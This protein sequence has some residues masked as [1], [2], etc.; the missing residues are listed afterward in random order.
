[1]AASTCPDGEKIYMKKVLLLSSVL[2]LMFAC[3]GNRTSEGPEFSGHPALTFSRQEAETV[4]EMLGVNPYV[5]KAVND[6]KSRIE[7]SMKDGIDVPQP[8][9]A[10][11]YAHEK[12]KQNY[13]DMKMAGLLYVI[14]GNVKYAEF[15]KQMLNQY[16]ELYPTLGA[17]P[18]SHGQRPGKLFHQMLNETV[19]LL[20]TSQ[21]YDYIYDYLTPDERKRYE[22]N[23]FN[24]MADWFTKDHPEEFNRIHNHGMWAAASV[25]MYGLVSGQDDYVQMALYGT[26]KDGNG[27]FMAQVDKLFSPDGYYMEGAYYV[28][29]ALRPL[30]FF[31]EALERKRPDLKIYEFKDHII[32]KA[33]YAAIQM[34]YPN[35]VFIPINDASL[36]MN[37]DAPGVIFG[38]ATIFDRYGMDENLLGLAKLQ[39]SIYLNRGGLAIAKK[40]ADTYDAI[41]VPSWPSIEFTDGNDGLQGGF[42]ILRSEKEGRQAMLAMKYGVHGLGHGHFDELNFMYFY[43]DR[44]ILPDYGYSRWINVEPKFGGR[45]L[46]E[47]K[48]WAKQTLAHNTVVVDERCQNDAKQADA[49]EMHGDRH[50]FDA[51]NPE[52]QIMS[53]KADNYYPGVEM[54]R[55]MLLLTPDSL[56]HPVIV[57][58]YRLKSNKSHTY[59]YPLHFRGQIMNTTLKYEANTRSMTAMGAANGYEHLW[60]TAEAPV[61]DDFSFTWLD[62]QR[63]TSFITDVDAPG[64]VYFTRIGADDPNYNLRSEPALIYRRKAS[65]TVFASVIETHGEFLEASEYTRDPYPRFTSVDVLGQNDEAT[66]IRIRGEKGIDWEIAVNNGPSTDAVHTV[67]C[68][69]NEITLNGNYTFIRK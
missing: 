19:W 3:A 27:G 44:D 28:R 61:S 33:F 17:H 22:E 13:R 62:G 47:N 31:S 53:A 63:F 9:E 6:M 29:Y 66:L 56:P 60:K 68:G 18:L 65:T 1:M 11:G 42:G 30:L 40:F 46:P 55:T 24:P 41:H 20:N 48:T 35:G 36:T 38:V 10:G 58:I 21:A 16:A 50:F 37:I 23:I 52:I 64:T 5:T 43:D 12:H 59:D 67:S 39:N 8:G 49:D 54:Q 45:Y 34:T 4:R 7:Q 15:I 14:D 26:E 69:G 2:F 32:K 57:D 25:G 51:S